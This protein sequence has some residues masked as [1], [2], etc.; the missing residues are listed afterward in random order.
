M[1]GKRWTPYSS[2]RHYRGK[3]ATNGL[4][5]VS[6]R[7]RWWLAT[8]ACTNG[9]C[10]GDPQLCKQLFEVDHRIRGGVV[11]HRIWNNQ[12]AFVN[13]SAAGVDDVGDIPLALDFIGDEQRFL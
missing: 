7:N 9:F 13:I 5:T 1:H 8:C 2:C 6:L 4:T 3:P 12:L 10:A 11:G